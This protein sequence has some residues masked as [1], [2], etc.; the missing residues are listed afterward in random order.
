M[1]ENVSRYYNGPLSQTPNKYT[2]AYEIS[3][4]RAFPKS[5]T[6]KYFVHTWASGEDLTALAAQY[7]GG[8]KYWWRILEINPEIADPFAIA[9]GVKVRVPYGN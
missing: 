7:C 1:I 8:A 5:E 9:P 2:G 3:V 4:Y 6:V